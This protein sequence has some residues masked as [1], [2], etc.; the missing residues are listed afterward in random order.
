MLWDIIR[1]ENFDVASPYN[2]E[3]AYWVKLQQADI[4]PVDSRP[5]R[6]RVAGLAP[7]NGHRK[8]PIVAQPA[9][10]GWIRQLAPNRRPKSWRPKSWKRWRPTSCTSSSSHDRSRAV[11]QASGSVSSCSLTTPIAIPDCG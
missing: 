2:R 7:V 8:P 5:L 9:R 6:D 3:A 10:R 11:A 4:F 1:Y